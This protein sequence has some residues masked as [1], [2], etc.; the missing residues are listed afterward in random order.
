MP[1]QPSDFTDKTLIILEGNSNIGKSTLCNFIWNNR[2][3]ISYICVDMFFSISFIKKLIKK[4]QKTR[5]LDMINQMNKYLNMLESYDNP[6]SNISTITKN[7]EFKKHII[8]FSE[9]ILFYINRLLRKNKE[10]KLILLEGQPLLLC[11][12]VLLDLIKDRNI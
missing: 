5:K 4:T 6:T 9:L 1:G 12:K 10:I 3:D 2:H 8:I 11:S 7:I